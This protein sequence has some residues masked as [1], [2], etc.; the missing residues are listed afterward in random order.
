MTFVDPEIAAIVAQLPPRGKI[1]SI[2]QQRAG[3]AFG[4]SAVHKSLEP[5]LPKGKPS[6][7]MRL[8]ELLIIDRS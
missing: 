2:E 7:H 3:F 4:I 1:E 6:C 5:Q 8:C